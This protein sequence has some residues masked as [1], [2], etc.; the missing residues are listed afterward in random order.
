MRIS[1]VATRP[2]NT[3]TGT[4]PVLTG[5]LIQGFRPI[6]TAQLQFGL[7]DGVG[8]RLVTAV[9]GIVALDFHPRLGANIGANDILRQR[10]YAAWVDGQFDAQWRLATQLDR[11]VNIWILT[12]PN[13]SCYDFVLDA[14]LLDADLLPLCQQALGLLRCCCQGDWDGL[15]PHRV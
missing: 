8:F 13:N 3:T 12:T 2:S 6:H 14:P 10:N 11:D 7:N 9:T 5:Q 4:L 15:V 1:K